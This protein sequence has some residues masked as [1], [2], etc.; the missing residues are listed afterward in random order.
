MTNTQRHAPD[1]M[2]ATHS[3]APLFTVFTATFNR[4]HTL[5]RVHDSLCKQT[6]KD[7]EWLIVDDG[8]TDG[9]EDLVRS[10]IEHQSFPIRYIR[11][12][13]QG[14]HFAYNRGVEEANGELFLALDSD[15]TCSPYALARFH[16]HW[17]SIPAAQRPSFSGVTCLCQDQQ[18][19]ALGG[20]LPEAFIDGP[21]F[22]V[23]SRLRR[24]GEMWGFHRTDVLRQ[25]RFPEIPS[26]RF[27][28]EGLVWNRIGRRYQ[29]RF[30]NESL[31]HYFSSSDG[32]SAKMVA[33]RRQ[34]PTATLMYYIEV[35]DLPISMRDRLKAA[36][37]LWRFGLLS[38]KSNAVCSATLRHPLLMLLGCVPGLALIL[39]RR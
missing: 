16:H 28:P 18:G 14:K 8:S 24:E 31:R 17:L 9:T 27:V 19:R 11:Q 38:A 29:I 30:V 21:P 35:L 39:A 20:P 15:D 7:F 5:H 4:A 32:L 6:L 13:N 3:P 1:P 34:S 36:A 12:V 2:D 25:F 23:I 10:W 26:E 37:N 22:E 33:I